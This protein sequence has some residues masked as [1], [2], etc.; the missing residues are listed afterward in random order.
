MRK[1]LSIILTLFAFSNVASAQFSQNSKSI[2][3][4]V[5]F[6]Q[7]YYDHENIGTTLAVTPSMGYFVKDDIAVTASFSLGA[8]G[9]DGVWIV[10]DASIGVGG[11]YYY[12]VDKGALYVGDSFEFSRPKALPSMIPEAGYLLGLNKSVF[13]D[14]GLEYLMGLGDNK[15]STITLEVGI[16]TFF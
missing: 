3:G 12:E 8:F 2:G 7:M 11:K 14:F 9:D 15:S 13:L 5:I 16:A 6:D 10:D 1:S 4:S